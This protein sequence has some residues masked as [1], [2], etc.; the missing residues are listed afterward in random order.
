MAR[1]IAMACLM[2][3]A[4]A[5]G[6]SDPSTMESLGESVEPSAELSAFRYH[7]RGLVSLND[8]C[9]VRGDALS[10]QVEPIYVNGRP[11]G[12]C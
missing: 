9:P 5:C 7:D 11:I 2:L 6:S 10:G 3:G 1:R 12:F 8:H 4:L